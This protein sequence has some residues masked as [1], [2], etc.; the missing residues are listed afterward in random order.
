MRGPVAEWW[1]R[2][3]DLLLGGLVVLLGV[4]V[5]AN[6]FPGAFIVDDVLIVDQN[7]LVQGL[8]LRAI[9]TSDYWGV[10]AD[11]GLYRPLTILSLAVNR[12]LLGHEPWS[13]HLVNVLLHAGVGLAFFQLLRGWQT[14]Q[15]LSFAAALLFAVHP[16]H[17]EVVNEVIGRSELLAALF[18]LLALRL[19]QS[20]RPQRWWLCG[21]AYLLALLSKEHA[22]TFVAVLVLVD[23]F[24][25]RGHR[26]RLPLYGGLLALTGLWLLFHTY[27]VDRG[28]MG[29]PPFYAIYS[30]L[31]FMPAGWR[32]LTALKLQLLYLAKLA[33]PLGLQGVYSGPEIDLPVQGLLSLWGLGS[34]LAVL[35][36]AALAVYGWRRRRLEGL[37]ILLYTT[38]F[39]V[40]ANIVF[41]T[42]V[43]LAERFAYL[44][45]L[46]FCL[47]VTG[48]VAGLSRAR[49]SRK[50]MVAALVLVSLGLAGGTWFRNH[51]YRDGIT[52][53]GVD[54]ARDPRN[55]LAGMFLG[56]AYVHQGEFA[57]AEEVYRQILAYRTDLGSILEDMAWVQLR[58]NR[59]QQ[60]VEYALQVVALERADLSEKAL[61]TLAESYTLLG[62]PQEVVGLLDM[63]SPKRNPPGFFWELQGKA[64]E[65]LGDLRNAVDCYLRAGEPPLT[66]DLPQRLERL[67]RQLG[68]TEE[69]D[70]ARQWVQEREQARRG[71]SQ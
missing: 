43:A 49:A 15:G 38:S 37:A 24:F 63:L 55:V 46:W 36:A 8:D 16:I 42:E 61:A 51:D 7:P 26:K 2:W 27:G 39:S 19:A 50:A 40:T 34:G 52:L 62:R 54:F 28:S 69:A 31:A 4:G 58:Q 56:D 9:F 17:T 10:G 25:R 70:K 20:E 21:L 68:E 32:V 47:G 41:P 71:E 1:C 14:A 64:F 44:P 59:P 45:S 67:L 60:A 18:F 22:V 3:G 13:Y 66:S 48:A 65:Q 12:W 11:R 53:F 57:K 6:S 35:A 5:Y 30:P 29:R 33:W 23:A